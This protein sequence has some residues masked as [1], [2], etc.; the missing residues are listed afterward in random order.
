MLPQQESA[1][2]ITFTRFVTTL[3][4]NGDDGDSIVDLML[5]VR[6][7]HYDGPDRDELFLED[8]NEVMTEAIKTGQSRLAALRDYLEE[9]IAADA[10]EIELA[11]RSGPNP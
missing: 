4:Q 2:I 10:P 8:I 11:L 3:C 9:I 5:T 7:F 6:D 1:E